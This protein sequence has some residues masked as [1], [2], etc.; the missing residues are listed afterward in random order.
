MIFKEEAFASFFL[1]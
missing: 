1:K